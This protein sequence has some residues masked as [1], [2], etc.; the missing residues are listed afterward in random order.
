MQDHTPTNKSVQHL[1][2]TIAEQAKLIDKLQAE[3]SKLQFLN[4][5]LSAKLQKLLHERYGKKSEKVPDEVLPLADEASVTPEEA[6]VILDAEATISVGGHERNKPKREP[7]PKDF[8]R[9][10]V[11]HDLPLEQQVC[12]CGHKLHCIGE[13]SNEKL[14]YIPAQIKVIHTV[15]KKYGCRNCEIGITPAPAPNDFL[16]KSLAA[17]GLLAHVAL[18]KY[19]DHCPLYRQER[20]WQRIGV[21]IPRSTLCNWMLMSAE[22]LQILMPLMRQEIISLDYARADE[23]P[24]Q[25]LEENKVRTS[26]RAYMWV[27]ASGRTEKAIIVYN[28]AMTRAGRVAEEFFTD[29]NG[30]LQTDGF[31][32]YNSICST[33]NVTSVGCMAHARRKFIAIVKMAKTTGAAHY[34]VAI[35]AKLYKI[36]ADIKTNKFDFDKIREYRQQHSKPIILEF[37]DWLTQKQKQA[38]PKSPMGQAIY[39]FIAH[40]D[41]LVIY[42][43]HG[44]LDIDNNFT[45]QRIRPFSIGRKNW[46]FMGNERGGEAAAIFFSLIESAKANKLNTYAYFRYLMTELP[47]VNQKDTITLKEMLP[48]RIDN[49]ILEKYLN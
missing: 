18:S 27:F 20:I 11:I 25:V 17:P 39:Y 19:E 46:M 13:D 37:K 28:F 33:D 48:H 5:D 24:V 42:L 9:E 26:K 32:G 31:A 10:T 35:I 4:E 22:R 12:G 40:W 29:F 34:A 38:P 7:L 14:D 16:P 36:E 45:E 1:E 8:A 44:F 23:T 3:N 21:D 41:A 15:Y 6:A 30:F 49:A 2:N 47:N 43:E